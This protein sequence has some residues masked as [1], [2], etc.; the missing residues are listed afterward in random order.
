MTV[1]LKNVDDGILQVLESLK[2]LKKDLE[3]EKDKGGFENLRR[4]ML[5]D[6]KEPQNYAV[7][8]R[9]KDK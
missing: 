2:A 4:F 8:E 3:I 7:F 1:V 6:L 5:E 9:L